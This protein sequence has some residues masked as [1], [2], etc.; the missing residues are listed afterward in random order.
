[1]VVEVDDGIVDGGAEV[2]KESG[3]GMDRGDFFTKAKYPTAA[4]KATTSR[5]RMM[6]ANPFSFI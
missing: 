3:I 5:E 4:R 1:M 6:L 2:K